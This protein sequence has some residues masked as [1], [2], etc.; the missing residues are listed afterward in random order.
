MYEGSNLC[1]RILVEIF[2]HKKM[3]LCLFKF[4]T[5]KQRFQR[6]NNK[7]MVGKVYNF[8]LNEGT[9]FLGGSSFYLSVAMFQLSRYWRA[10]GVMGH[11]H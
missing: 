2:E 4:L 8:K 6:G 5:G 10:C 3:R 9:D 7:N 1:L 11:L